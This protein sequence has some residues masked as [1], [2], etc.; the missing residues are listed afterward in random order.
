MVVCFNCYCRSTSHHH[1][2]ATHPRLHVMSAA[3]P[4]PGPS[5]LPTITSEADELAA[6]AGVVVGAIGEGVNGVGV[7]GVNGVAPEVDGG[8]GEANGVNGHVENGDVRM[9]GDAP[10]GL[11][12]GQAPDAEG[13]EEVRAEGEG[14]GEGEGETETVDPNALPKEACETLYIQN[15]NEKVRIPGEWGDRDSPL[16][17]VWVLGAGCWVLV[18]RRFMIVVLER[19]FAT[20]CGLLSHRRVLLGDRPITLSHHL[21]F[22]S[23]ALPSL[24][25][26]IC[27]Q[28]SFYEF[29]PP[30]MMPIAHLAACTLRDRSRLPT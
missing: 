11:A 20:Q 6:E 15:L 19:L 1:T 2:H 14:E 29:L 13:K 25:Y 16:G 5:R 8:A 30:P 4:T 17:W 12:D 7:D 21:S 28:P 27:R 22:G 18:T 9:G 23:P 3:D 10:E 26:F 24:P